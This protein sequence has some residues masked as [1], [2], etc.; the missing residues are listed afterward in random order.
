MR[1]RSVQITTAEMHYLCVGHLMCNVMGYAPSD[2]TR[3]TNKDPITATFLDAVWVLRKIAQREN[4]RERLKAYKK[5]RAKY[6]TVA[7]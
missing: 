6:E 7:A 1:T 3:G 4:N 5:K 2:G